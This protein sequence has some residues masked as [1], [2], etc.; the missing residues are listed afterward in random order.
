MFY[1]DE[2]RLFVENSPAADAGDVLAQKHS[3]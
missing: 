3:C 2:D 1:E